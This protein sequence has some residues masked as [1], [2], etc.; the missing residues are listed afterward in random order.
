VCRDIAV[1]DRTVVRWHRVVVTQSENGPLADCDVP[2]DVHR[3]RTAG[4]RVPV[5]DWAPAAKAHYVD[6]EAV[7][8]LREKTPESP[9]D[10]KHLCGSSGVQPPR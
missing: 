3:R 9:R 6:G 7:H 10:S 8:T 5:L 4:G 2:S 1:H